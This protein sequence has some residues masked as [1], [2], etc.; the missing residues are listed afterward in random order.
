MSYT[1]ENVSNFPNHPRALHFTEAH[2]LQADDVFAWIQRVWISIPASSKF[3]CAV[4]VIANLLAYGFIFANLTLNHDAFGAITADGSYHRGTGRWMADL[5]YMKILG[6]F[7]IIW[8]YDLA[9]M[10]LF[11]VAGFSICRTLGIA[12]TSIRLTILLCYTLFPYT[13]NYYAYPF[14]A[15]I[16]GFASVMSVLGIELGRSSSLRSKIVGGLC[17][18]LS[19]ASY[20]AFVATALTLVCLLIATR[21]CRTDNWKEVGRVLLNDLAPQLGVIA[22]GCLLYALSV[23][24]MTAWLGVVLTDYQG[25]NSMMDITSESIFQGFKLALKGTLTFFGRTDPTFQFGYENPYYAGLPKIINCVVALIAAINLFQDSS[26][27]LIG[28]ASVGFLLLGLIAPRSVQVLHPE[29]NY[30][31]L[32]L[33]GYALYL[34]GLLAIALDARAKLLRVV[35]QGAVIVLI[36]SFIHSNNVA[37]MSLTLDYQAT[38]H[39]ANRVLARAEALPNYGTLNYPAR[40]QF[41]FIGNG[42]QISQWQYRGRP[43]LSSTGISDGIPDIV[44]GSLFQLLRVN[45]TTYGV[46]KQSLELAKRYAETHRAWPAEDSLTVLPDGTIVVVLENGTLDKGTA[47]R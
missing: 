9:G 22:G 44:F 11:I 7:E 39:W 37:A 24:G 35:V 40:K 46:S 17:V 15:P 45:A 5:L 43:F 34:A 6:A 10:F 38:L 19:L 28:L 1:K 21:V 26:R 47:S 3:I 31:E 30:H 13:C 33:G 14:Y 25:A 4:V 2:S 32:A 16:Y 23:R 8:L 41:V 12:D 27:K 36:F 29:A 42:Y 20:Q 18:A